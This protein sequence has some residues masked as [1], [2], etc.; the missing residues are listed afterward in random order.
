MKFSSDRSTFVS[1]LASVV[2]VTKSRSTLPVLTSVRITAD[3][4]L[5]LFATDLEI[6]LRSGLE[7]E[8]EKAGDV[9]VSATKLLEFGRAAKCERISLSVNAKHLAEVRC[10][11][12]VMR[13]HGL[14]GDDMPASRPITTE[15]LVL[16]AGAVR[17]ALCLVRGFQNLRDESRTELAGVNLTATKTAWRL[18]A[19]DGNRAAF[20]TT[21]GACA[22]TGSWTIPAKS[23]QEIYRMADGDADI[24]LACSDEGMMVTA[25]S[26]G[27]TTKLIEAGFPNLDRIVP[28]WQEEVETDREELLQAIRMVSLAQTDEREHANLTFSK[29]KI[30]LALVAKDGGSAEESVPATYRGEEIVLGLNP[31]YVV[32]VLDAISTEQV[33]LKIVDDMSP[34]GFF[35]D[36]GFTSVVMPIRI[37]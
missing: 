12:A 14:P 24:R 8:V 16:P 7:A 37:T 30:S 33:T 6:Q 23:V 10:G 28:E 32:D 18:N 11:T 29:G 36:V 25:G 35:G 5:E 31:S 17:H 15:P 13:L 3:K 4:G 20:I 26:Q 27:M 34:V 9:C 21:P 1:A 19:T 22:V 2:G